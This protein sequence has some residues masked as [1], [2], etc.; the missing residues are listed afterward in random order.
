MQNNMPLMSLLLIM[1]TQDKQ[2]ICTGSKAQ[3][4]I[5]FKNKQ[6]PIK[7]A[8]LHD[9][10]WHYVFIQSTSRLQMLTQG[11]NFMFCKFIINY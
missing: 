8:D 1:H 5:G 6:R 2:S 3:R 10:L 4:E 11:S 7:L 9:P